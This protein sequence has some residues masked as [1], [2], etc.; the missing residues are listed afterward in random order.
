MMENVTLRD[1]LTTGGEEELNIVENI[2]NWTDPDYDKEKIKRS[3][4]LDFGDDCFL[5]KNVMSSDECQF[6]MSSAEKLGYD[7]IPE[8]KESYRNT[9]RYVS[10]ITPPTHTHTHAYAHIH[11]GA[12]IN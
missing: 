11:A 7:E 2:N 3:K 12:R 4:I 6:Y 9:V 10:H 5:L 1:N 8:S